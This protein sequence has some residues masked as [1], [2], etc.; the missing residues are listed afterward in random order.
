M[1]ALNSSQTSCAAIIGATAQ[2]Y[3][4]VTADV[5]QT[6]EVQETATNA[7]GPSIPGSSA[8]TAVIAGAPPSNTAPPTIS[9]QVQQGYVLTEAHGSWTN[10]PTSYSYAWQRCTNSGTGCTPITGAT[11][12]TYTPVAADVGSTLEVTESATNEDGPSTPAAS[13]TTSVVLPA[14]PVETALPT[15]TGGAVQGQTLTEVHGT[16]TN[17]P[18]GYSYQWL[19]CSNLGLLCVAIGG[20]TSQTYVPVAGDVGHTL[21]VQET[22]SNAGGGGS[23][24]TSA[25]TA[26]VVAAAPV[27]T[28]P[29]TISGTPQEGQMLIEAH[30]TWTNSPTSYTY[31][32]MRC[33]STGTNCAAL[34][35]A[36][37]Q[38]YVPV[39][40]DVGHELAVQEVASNAAGPG[41]AALSQPTSIVEPPV[42]ANTTPPTITG[43]V[44]QGATLTEVNGT[45]PTARR[46]T[47]TNGSAAQAQAPPAKQ[48]AG[49]HPRHMSRELPRRARTRGSGDSQQRR[50]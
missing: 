26:V 47:P 32:W 30:G 8:V 16:W 34:N 45:G 37:A 27:S 18:T 42:P 35:G 50:R 29:P 1:A 49:R 5:G 14:V 36:T 23:P 24:A 48:S 46:T 31:Q 28:S 25:A 44:A 3:L 13:A 11:A 4:L 7:G 19:Q 2:T 40:A 6:L 12:Q 21:E 38:T 20:A 43:T 41:S 17:N 22:A 10:Q 39:A 33:T 9:G 15:I